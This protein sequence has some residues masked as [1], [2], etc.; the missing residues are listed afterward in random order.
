MQDDLTD[1]A[2]SSPVSPDRAARGHA[3][4]ERRIALGIK[5]RA[6]FSRRT[7]MARDTIAAAES[8]TASAN[9]YLE[10]EAWLN[11]EADRLRPGG[12]AEAEVERIE[13]DIFGPTTESTTSIRYSVSGPVEAADELRRQAT[14]LA[15]DLGLA[16]PEM[17]KEAPERN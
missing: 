13:F 15:R 3:I 5:T 11:A 6:E 12:E 10:L 7:G 8:G 17:Q 9:T 14:E 1:A 4:A 2:R 16:P